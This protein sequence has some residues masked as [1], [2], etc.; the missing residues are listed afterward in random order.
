MEQQMNKPYTQLRRTHSEKGLTRFSDAGTERCLAGRE[1]HRAG[2]IPRRAD[3]SHLIR[4]PA[5]CAMTP[6]CARPSPRP[7]WDTEQTQ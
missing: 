5:Q 6:V 2:K 1:T 3:T 4:L 7:C